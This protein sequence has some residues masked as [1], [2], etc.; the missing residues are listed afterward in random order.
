MIWQISYDRDQLPIVST[1]W[2]R[3]KFSVLIVFI[4]FVIFLTANILVQ[5][6]SILYTKRINKLLKD[7]IRW[8]NQK[9][10]QFNSDGDNS[11]MEDYSDSIESQENNLVKLLVLAYPRYLFLFQMS[12]IAKSISLVHFQLCFLLLITE[13]VVPSL[14]IF[15]HHIQILLIFMNLSL[16]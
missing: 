1:M 12:L 9:L 14:E 15:Y 6:N 4:I 11:I 7:T 13:L 5:E 2:S 16:E 3:F 10:R 8:T